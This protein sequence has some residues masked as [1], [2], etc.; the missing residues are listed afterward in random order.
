MG[1]PATRIK[2][3][4]FSRDEAL[5]KCPEGMRETFLELFRRIDALDLKINYY[6]LLHNKRTNPP[7]DFLLKKF[8]DEEQ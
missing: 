3:E 2:R 5:A 6:E 8:S 4:V 1:M 7:R